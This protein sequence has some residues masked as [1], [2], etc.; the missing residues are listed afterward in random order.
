MTGLVH[1]L[2]GIQR[3][4]E[5]TA[6]R[7]H[8]SSLDHLGLSVALKSY[9]EDFGRQ[10]SIAVRYAERNLPRSIPPR[11]GLTVYR[12]LQEALRNVAKHSGA[13]RAAVSVAGKNDAIVL[14]V[15]DSGR[16]FDPSRSKRRGLG[17]ISM[18]ERVREAGGS[19]TVKSTPG[20]GVLID[21]R[22]PLAARNRGAKAVES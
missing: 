6:Y 12:V 21:V 19:F 18:E 4:V 16:G 1:R 10:N 8:P 20:K 9:C 7:L 14:T 22:V 15:K 11:L 13:G 5:Q 2:R 3:D 17:L